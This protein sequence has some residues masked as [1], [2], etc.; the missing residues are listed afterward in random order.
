MRRSEVEV[1]GAYKSDEVE[2]E[3]READAGESAAGWVLACHV[4]WSPVGLL[5]VVWGEVGGGGRE[6][7]LGTPVSLNPSRI[8]EP[9]QVT[10]HNSPFLPLLLPIIYTRHADY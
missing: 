8:K 7:T 4:P 2:D 5:G 6:A 3:E 1:E 10:G 9:P